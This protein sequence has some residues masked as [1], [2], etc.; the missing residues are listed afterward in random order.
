MRF[1]SASMCFL[2]PSW[3]SVKV[4][5]P[6]VRATLT[7]VFA[8]LW[9]FAPS[10]AEMLRRRLVGLLLVSGVTVQLLGL[11]VDPQRL[12]LQL[13]MPNTVY[14]QPGWLFHLALSHLANRP[15]EIVE[16]I[17]LSGGR[18]EAY[19]PATIPTHA[20]PEIPLAEARPP[21]G[22]IRCSVHSDPG[23]SISNI[24][25]PQRDRSICP[26]LCAIRRWIGA[27]GRAYDHRNSMPIEMPIVGASSQMRVVPRRGIPDQVG[28]IVAL[29]GL[30]LSVFSAVSLSGPG[31]IDIVDGQGVATEVAQPRRPRGPR[32]P[33]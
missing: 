8:L 29:V 3:L 4:I 33:R 30:S 16:I 24:S 17:R 28:W 22:N 9:L 6:G 11:S 19:S 23:G 13:A 18:A 26:G 32:D 7:P 21:S 25:K 12:D 1:H 20:S 14:S 31:R 2:F 15:R 5:P 10:G 27:R